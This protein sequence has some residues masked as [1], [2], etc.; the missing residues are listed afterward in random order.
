MADLNL[1]ESL[2]RAQERRPSSDHR[3]GKVNEQRISRP[4]GRAA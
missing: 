2:T 1:K 3:T 4:T